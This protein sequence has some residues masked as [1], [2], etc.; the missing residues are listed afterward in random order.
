[1]TLPIY[2]NLPIDGRCM[3]PE[4]FEEYI[5][6][7]KWEKPRTSIYLHHTWKP[8]VEDWRG[9]KTIEAMR[10]TY[11]TYQWYDTAGRL[12]IGWDKGPHLFV[13]PD[14]IWLFYDIRKDGYHAGGMW[15]VGSIGIEMV[16]DYDQVAPSGAVWTNTLAVLK[17]LTQYLNI[18]IGELR[19]HR[20]VST[21]TC[22]GKKV[23]KATVIAAVNLTKL[24]SEVDDEASPPAPEVRDYDWAYKYRMLD[25]PDH[26]LQRY[27]T[28]NEMT[29]VSP[30]FWNDENPHDDA[31]YLWAR[32]KTGTY[33][34]LQAEPPDW[35]VG[36]VLTLAK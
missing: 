12:H 29:V 16:G 34:L 4:Q 2:E 26:A 19:F 5:K 35:R 21:K 6:N 27:A 23:E 1:M 20:D 7:L 30:E 22:P 18:P 31:A 33:V 8:T 14:G 32:R 36:W 9:I 28:Q 13:A 11:M 24:P 3:A 25:T 10:R 17:V 15:N